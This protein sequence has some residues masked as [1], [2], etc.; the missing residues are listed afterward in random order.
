MKI[1]KIHDFNII[2]CAC[3]DLLSLLLLREVPKK[4][5]D[6]KKGGAF[7]ILYIVQVVQNVVFFGRQNSNLHFFFPPFMKK[8][9]KDHA[10]SFGENNNF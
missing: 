6:L 10:W 1:T 5:C 3:S 7:N 4:F 8:W 9:Q 2:L